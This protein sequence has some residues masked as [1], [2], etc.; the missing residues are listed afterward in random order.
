[1]PLRLKL[2][3]ALGAPVRLAGLTPDWTHS[4]G[5]SEIAA[6]EL[7]HGN[8]RHTLGELFV[9]AG[10]SADGEIEFLGEL[11]KVHGIGA[12][13]TSGSIRVEGHVGDH[14][15]AEM[16]GGS[17]EILGGAGDWIGREMCGGRIHVHG[18][19][20]DHAAAAPVGASR[21]MAG[22]ELLIAGNAGHGL[23][24]R[25]RRGL[26]AVS[27]SAGDDVGAEMLAGTILLGGS[28]GKRPGTE[29]RRGTLAL[30]G[31]PPELPLTYV[32]DNRFRPQ[33]L[34]LLLVHLRRAGMA[35]PSD[36]SRGDYL[37]HHGDMLVSGRGEILIRA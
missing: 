33:F 35:F 37:L 9:V 13:M 7:F 29:L 5:L 22:G 17:L 31:P 16:R 2:K 21:G 32:R 15:G 26:V 11:S 25:M 3:S 14:A 12:G 8:K 36:S 18:K 24:R 30:I 23:G 20:A 34:E 4:R 6:R 1:M 27:G 19:V 28:C 10:N